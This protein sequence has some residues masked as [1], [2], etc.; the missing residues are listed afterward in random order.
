MQQCGLSESDAWLRNQEDELVA[1]FSTYSLA[2]KVEQIQTETKPTVNRIVYA[3]A[4]AHSFVTPYKVTDGL[5]LSMQNIASARYVASDLVP[6]YRVRLEVQRFGQYRHKAEISRIAETSLIPTLS[7]VSTSEHIADMEMDAEME[8]VSDSAT[9]DSTSLDL[10]NH[11]HPPVVDELDHDSSQA[12]PYMSL[13]Y[14]RVQGT[15]AESMGQIRNDH[16]A[17]S[18]QA[19]QLS[20]STQESSRGG[21][22]VPCKDPVYNAC[23]WWSYG[24]DGLEYRWECM[25]GHAM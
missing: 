7:I 18:A 21:R 10:D 19:A 25:R 22:Y 1:R 3:S 17:E 23:N 20:S 11:P 6:R 13:G 4:A 14:E 8:G 2:P 24:G 5:N 16:S 12:E 9:T 15:V